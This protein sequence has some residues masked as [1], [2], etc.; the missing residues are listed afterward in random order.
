MEPSK[1]TIPI[2]VAIL[3]IVIVVAAAA[4]YWLSKPD[5]VSVEQV[6]QVEQELQAVEDDTDVSA[7]VSSAVET[8]AEKLPE[9]NPFSSYKNP[10][11]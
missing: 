9:T 11:E 5:N 2:Q 3:A 4:Y 10:F 1:S 8:P 6:D 7:E